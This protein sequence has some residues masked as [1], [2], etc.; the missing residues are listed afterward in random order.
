MDDRQEKGDTRMKGREA[1]PGIAVAR[2]IGRAAAAA[3]LVAVVLGA[4]PRVAHSA[5]AT[6]TVGGKTI[7]C[8]VTDL[9]TTR[10]FLGGEWSS[11]NLK[12]EFCNGQNFVIT[13]CS[14]LE[15]IKKVTCYRSPSQGTP[16]SQAC[17]GSTYDL[18]MSKITEFELK[19][20][21]QGAQRYVCESDFSQRNITVT[22]LR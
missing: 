4:G 3:M 10:G 15:D 1:R 5:D 17:N 16:F 18:Q 22:P 19:A 2:A 6:F 21:T 13:S 20:G 14:V 11:F 12:Y 9:V 7:T 8:T